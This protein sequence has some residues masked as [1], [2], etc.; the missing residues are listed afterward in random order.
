MSAVTLR[1][2]AKINLYLHV[3]GKRSDGYHLLDSMAVFADSVTDVVHVEISD[4]IACSVSGPFSQG[5][6][7]DNL[8]LKACHLFCE[9]M[10]L[11][12]GATIHLEKNI[13]QGA[14]LGGG[15]ADAAAAIKALEKLYDLP[16]H[17]ESRNGFL[18]H[19]G[20]DVP[21]CYAAKPCRF[22]GIGEKI[23][24]IPPLPK[25]HMLLIHPGTHSSTK[26]IFAR[27][28]G[29]FDQPVSIP[30]SFGTFD[31]LIAFLSGS[32]NS[33]SAAAEGLTPDIGI[34]RTFLQTQDGCAL[35]RM[36]G[37]GSCV[38]GL[39]EH[40]EDCAKARL[41]CERLHPQWWVQAA[42]I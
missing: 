16:L 40:A 1:A 15:S 20:A 11:R 17:G 32:G 33:L 10:G 37:S 6:G 13:P 2:P 5:I 4:G 38:F 27:Y 9:T 18:L 26:E 29:H 36:T 42:Q 22:E 21:V 3:T 39:F 30:P 25:F 34:V 24:H 35:T 19:L 7:D 31:A 23:T 41:M 12:T 8:V 14:G 28:D